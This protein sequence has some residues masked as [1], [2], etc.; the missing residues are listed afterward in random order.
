MGDNVFNVI[1]QEHRKGLINMT[2]LL[3]L[4]LQKDQRERHA[5]G[6]VFG[7]EHPKEASFR[8]WLYSRGLLGHVGVKQSF[9]RDFTVG[10]R[11]GPEDDTALLPTG[12]SLLI[13]S[14]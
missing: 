6:A 9:C 8:R 11:E 3:P 7:R 13:L 14:T 1:S 2:A 4:C 10:M 5:G 12:V